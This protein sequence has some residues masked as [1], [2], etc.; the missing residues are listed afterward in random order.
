MKK[1]LKIFLEKIKK[2]H[3]K[4]ESKKRMKREFV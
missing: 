4:T 3:Q 2:S 1:I